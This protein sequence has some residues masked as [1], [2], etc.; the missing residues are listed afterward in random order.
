MARSTTWLTAALPVAALSLALTACGGDSGG[1]TDDAGGGTDR[2]ETGSGTETDGEDAD[3]DEETGTE[4]DATGDAGGGDGDGPTV[5]T[6][7]IGETSHPV[8]YYAADDEVAVFTMTV[9]KVHVGEA[10]D[11]DPELLSN[12]DTEGQRPV[13]VHTTYTHEEGEL[14]WF[15]P[16]EPT[17]L[18]MYLADG[19]RGTNI[20]GVND[21]GMPEGCDG[22]P[23]HGGATEP[24][25]TYP[26]CR[27]FLVP[28][29]VDVTEVRWEMRDDE[30]VW[31]V[32]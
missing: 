8:T 17:Y 4:T 26:D 24:G 29:D 5:T 12:I 3:A 13:H 31:A 9:D 20:R 25:D 32:D 16:S 1:G 14:T 30:L 19:E 28:E 6:F 15:L 7:A 10:A 11:I 22:S 21:F 18:R 23:M 27:T 2:S